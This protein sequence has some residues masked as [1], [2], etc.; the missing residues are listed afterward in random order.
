MYIIHCL[1]VLMRKTRRRCYWVTN[2]FCSGYSID[3]FDISIT[4]IKNNP[5]KFLS[6]LNIYGDKYDVF[7]KSYNHI[8]KKQ[9]D[10]LIHLRNTQ[11]VRNVFFDL[12]V[13][14]AISPK[15][16]RFDK[17]P[18]VNEEHFQYGKIQS[19]LSATMQILPSHIIRFT[20][21]EELKIIMNEFLFHLKNVN[22]GY[23]N[24]IYWVAWLIQWEKMNKKK[25]VK[26]EIECRDISEVDPKHCK[27]PI[28]MLWESFLL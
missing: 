21:P 24:A 15:T 9:K 2:V 17:Y 27:D 22:G 14:M 16:K 8:G 20:D 7:T 28:W 12:V 18:K 3:L 6:C 5:C 10:Q 19:K 1:S 25:K 23:E 4:F 13:T 26:F 11:S